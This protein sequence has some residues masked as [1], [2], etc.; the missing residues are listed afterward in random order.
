[1]R[2]KDKAILVTGSDG[3]NYHESMADAREAIQLSAALKAGCLVVYSGG[4]NGHTQNH[5]RRLFAGAV[6][7][8]LP[9]IEE[10]GVTP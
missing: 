3:H 2:L 9:W 6:R 7:E 5:A 4:R 8:L 1:M 10:M